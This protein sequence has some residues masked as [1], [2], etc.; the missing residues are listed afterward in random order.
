MA[1]KIWTNEEYELLRDNYSIKSKE[2]LLEMFQGRTWGAIKRKGQQ[3]N[4]ER[5]RHPHELN[6]HKDVDGIKYKQCKK[7][8]EYH[9]MD[10]NHYN[11]KCDT[12]DGF[13]SRCRK[14]QGY[15]FKPYV[16]EG[17][18]I[19]KKCDRELPLEYK[20]FPKINGEKDF[21]YVCRECSDHYDGFLDNSFVH[22]ISWN[23]EETKIFLE[24]YPFYTNEEM[25]N[26]FYPDLSD[27]QMTDKA[28]TM[29]V[30]KNE[31]TYWRG[32]KQQAS[33]TSEKLKG[34]EKSEETRRKLSETKKKQFAEGIYISPWKGRIVSEE[35]RK[36]LS[37]RV[38]G[39]WSGENNPR[40][41]NPLKGELNGNWQGGITNLYQFLRENISEWKEESMKFCNYECILTGDWFDNIHHLTPFKNIVYEAMDILNIEVKQDISDYSEEIRKSII[42]EV[43]KLHKKYGLGLCLCKEIHKLFHDTY[44]YTNFTK[45]DF[46]EFINRYFSGEFDNNL[47]EKH[48]SIN[49]KKNIEEVTKVISFLL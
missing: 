15:D 21:R 36:R 2:E 47:S 33:K 31:E 4:E 48:K 39:K 5:T 27:K 37:D 23:E 49:N 35:E 26:L 25:R 11:K 3:L 22:K 40:H 44:N 42:L 8:G 10:S 14:C 20:Y 19:C 7:C 17:Y 18:R 24:R 9:P 43:S 30:S 34:R 6:N 28:F 1:S 29:R 45:E 12:K 46:S 16:K 38:K 13:T 41:I 32:R